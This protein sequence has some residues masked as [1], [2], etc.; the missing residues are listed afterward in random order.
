MLRNVNIRGLGI[1]A[2]RLLGRSII[3]LLETRKKFINKKESA[4]KGETAV[5]LL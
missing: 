3:I 4:L 1:Q 2:A 5:T